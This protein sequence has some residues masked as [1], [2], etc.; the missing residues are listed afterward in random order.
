[1]FT[2]WHSRLEEHFPFTEYGLASVRNDEDMASRLEKLDIVEPQD[3]NPVRVVFVPKTQ[4]TPRVIAIEP[5]CMQYIQQ[6]I[7]RWL[8]PR[9]ERGRYT[10]GQVNFTD[11]SVNQ[12][13]ALVSS[14]DSRFATMDLSEASDRVSSYLVDAMLES[15]PLFR[16]HVFACR[17][18]RAKLPDST[19]VELSKFASMGSALCFPMEAMVFF[20]IIVAARIRN[21]NRH[22]TPRS[23]QKYSRD[24]YVYGDDLLVP[25]DEA[26]FVGHWL[27]IFGL[28]VNENKS[29]WT[30]KF[31]ESCGTDAYNGDD[32]T[33]VYA[34]YE[35]PA[36]KQ[37]ADAIVSWVSMANQFYLK[38]F[39]KTTKALRGHLDKLL[40]GLPFL[41]PQSQGLSWNSYSNWIQGSRWSK[42]LMRFEVRTYVPS[43]VWRQDCI[44][45]DS[46]L[47]K[48][49][50]TIGSSEP[51][52]KEHL[53][54]VAARG[55]LTLKRRWVPAY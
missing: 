14:K 51:M 10:A 5:V 1:M 12:K 33:P 31:R 26:P 21:A 35:C 23:V 4:K 38:G 17:S 28:K 15:V 37:H 42:D 53:K 49:F 3:E 48:C 41:S 7:L 45:G 36:D 46:A 8:V 52:D 2:R 39:W 29:F 20:C 13:L 47:L 30:G 25:S 54:R 40:G 11:Q 19:I 16:E 24:V 44:D 27:S 22:V 55:K 32:V 34:R 43:S 9:I 18:T 6:G 50:S